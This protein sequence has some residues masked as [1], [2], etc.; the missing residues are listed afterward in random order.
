MRGRRRLWLGRRIIQGM[1]IGGVGAIGVI[2]ARIRADGKRMCRDRKEL[3]WDERDLG[4][5]RY[6]ES[7]PMLCLIPGIIASGVYCYDC[8]GTYFSHEMNIWN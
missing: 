3:T 5:A 1:G 8:V 2:A 6:M 7:R 4:A